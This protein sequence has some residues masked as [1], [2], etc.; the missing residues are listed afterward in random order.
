MYYLVQESCEGDGYKL[1]TQK[2]SWE[3][4]IIDPKSTFNH[5]SDNYSPAK[6]RY[7]LIKLK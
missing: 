4:E 3:S 1:S 5:T 6:R 7:L 2:N